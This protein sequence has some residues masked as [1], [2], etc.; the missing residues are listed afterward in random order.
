[1]LPQISHGGLASE[2]DAQE[3]EAFFKASPVV[4]LWRCCSVDAI[5]QDKDVSKFKMALQQNLDGIRAR[6]AWIEVRFLR[7]GACCSF[8]ELYAAFNRRSSGM[9]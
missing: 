4:L 7:I 2:K 3:T 8:S 6:V 1:M 9:A 5:W